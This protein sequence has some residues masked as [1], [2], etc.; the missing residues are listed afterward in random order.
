[1]IVRGLLLAAILVVAGCPSGRR[2]TVT[3]DESAE[4][5]AP[6][7]KPQKAKAK[8]KAKAKQPKKAKPKAKE[9]AASS[10]QPGVGEVLVGHAVWYGKDWHGRATAS[11][12]KFNMNAMTAAHRTLRLGTK[13]RVTN[14]RNGNS[15]VVRINDRGPYG[16]DKRRIIDVSLAAAKKLDFINAGWTEVTIE[17][18][19]VPPPRNKKGK[20]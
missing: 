17:V 20:R 6:K 18:L 2:R 19:E 14:Q 5:E 8:A 3:P 15:V 12:E 11:G 16:K 4:V 1:M 13:V 9:V 10:D 7:K